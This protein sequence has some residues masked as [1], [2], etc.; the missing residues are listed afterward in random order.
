MFKTSTEQKK[1][2]YNDYFMEPRMI[3]TIKTA[4]YSN[5]FVS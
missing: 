4:K 3:T 1:I 2:Y 5:N